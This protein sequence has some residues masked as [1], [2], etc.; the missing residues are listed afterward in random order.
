[1]GPV[2]SIHLDAVACS[3][4]LT[5]DFILVAV[6]QREPESTISR[7]H[8]SHSCLVLAFIHTY[9]IAGVR[10]MPMVSIV[11]Q[12]LQSEQRLSDM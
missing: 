3:Q 9:S 4:H 7:P 8:R 12:A 2:C 1:M 11:I 10:S 5:A 6:V